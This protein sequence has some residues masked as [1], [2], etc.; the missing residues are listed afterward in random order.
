M[1][2]EEFWSVPPIP[3]KSEIE[4]LPADKPRRCYC[5]HRI[6]LDSR[7]K[8]KKKPYEF[9]LGFT[10]RETIGVAV[11]NTRGVAAGKKSIIVGE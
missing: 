2:D 5:N 11:V 4:V 9:K 8:I 6:V 10:V 1:T 3:A 7:G